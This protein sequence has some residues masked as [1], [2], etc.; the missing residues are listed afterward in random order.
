MRSVYRDS[1]DLDL[2]GGLVT[3]VQSTGPLARTHPDQHDGE[4]IL[5]VEV[6]GGDRVD[7]G[8]GRIGWCE[9][10]RRNGH[11]RAE[12]PGRLSF[13]AIVGLAR[14]GASLP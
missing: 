1:G 8:Y 14:A 9:R 3:G 6:D 13:S 4:A 11:D 10:I 5:A 7:D 12:E 2:P